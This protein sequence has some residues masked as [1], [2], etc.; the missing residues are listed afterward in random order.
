MSKSHA[1]AISLVISATILSLAVSYFALAWIE[2]TQAPPGDNVP[3]PLNTSDETQTKA[4]RL[5]ALVFGDAI[6]PD[7]YLDPNGTTV[8]AGP[9][10]IGTTTSPAFT[11]DVA[12]QANADELCIEGD[13]KLSW[14]AVGVGVGFPGTYISSTE[15]SSFCSGAGSWS[16]PFTPPADAQDGIVYAQAGRGGARTGM[17]T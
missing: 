1:K 15:L 6:N 10:G 14:D 3:T 2:P 12:G 16:G 17:R 7:Y 5:N 11:L 9:V 4:G 8:L 13:C